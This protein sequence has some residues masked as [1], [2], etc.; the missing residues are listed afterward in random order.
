MA[1]YRNKYLDYVKNYLDYEYLIV[2]DT[3]IKGGYSW[4]GVA[5][6][7]SW[8]EELDAVAIGS[9]SLIYENRE[10]GPLRLYYDCLAYRRLNQP[11]GLAHNSS[12]IN[13]LCYNRG[14]NPIRLNSCFGGLCVYKLKDFKMDF[15]YKEYDCDHVTLHDQMN[16]SGLNVFM[17]PSQIVLY[18]SSPYCN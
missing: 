13:L 14:E 9:N 17:N 6:T 4:D 18:S 2:L 3:D 12:E 7:F 1:Y 16:E 15:S 8:F 11:K 5:N 10:S